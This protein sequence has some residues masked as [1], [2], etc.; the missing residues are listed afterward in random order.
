[1]ASTR[2]D[3][4]DATRAFIE[5]QPLFFVAS[6][7]L[8]AA[9]RVNVSPKGLDTFRVFSPTRVGYVDAGGSGNETSAHVLE[10]GRVTIMFCSFDAS[11]KVV[12]LFG[13][14]EVVLPSDE[15]WAETYALFPPFPGAR[16]IVLVHVDRVGSSCGYGVPVMERKEDRSLLPTRRKALGEG[17]YA[18]E[19]NRV[20]VDGL[21]THLGDSFS[22]PPE[23]A[24]LCPTSPS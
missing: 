8:S 2:P 17:W 11:P 5:R 4:N 9:G 19:G 23:D 6:A 24:A 12:R 14:G 3:I 21:P 7:P 13:R 10:N 18:P 1:M 20:S 15:R 16:Q 22:R